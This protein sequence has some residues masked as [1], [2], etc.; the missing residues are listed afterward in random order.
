VTIPNATHQQAAAA[1][2]AMLLVHSADLSPDGDQV[3]WSGSHI[4]GDEEFIELRI[5]P[6]D[7][8]LAKLVGCSP[9]DHSPA[10]APDGV[11]VAF[12]STHDG[13]SSISLVD[14]VTME[15]R[16]L[17]DAGAT[18]F[19]ITG[20]P[21]WSPDSTRLAFTAVAT[22]RKAGDPYR[23]TRVVGWVDGLGL[24]DD[25]AADIF[26]VDA[27]TGEHTRLTADDW[28]N[29]SPCWTRDGEAVVYIASWSPD[30]WESVA[31]IRS[32]SLMGVVSD[33]GTGRA[34]LGVNTLEDGAVVASTPGPQPNGLGRL[35][36]VRP[37]TDIED[38][39]SALG[40]DI[41]GDIIGD[42]AIGFVDPD[43]RLLVSDGGAIVRVQVGDRL[44]VER[45]TLAGSFGSEV[46]LSGAGCFYPLAISGSYLLYGSGSLASPPDLYVRNLTT[47]RD[48]Q[49]SDTAAHNQTV[50]TKVVVEQFWANAN[51]GPPIDCKFLRPAHASTALPTVLLIHGG[52]KSAFG[53]AFF[54]DAR[55]L[56]EA[57]FGVLMANP[58]GSRGYGVDFLDAI[59]GDWGNLDFADLMAAVDKA[60]ALNLADPDR[61][62]VSGL[63]YGGY[64]SSWI[65]GHTHRF[66]GAVIENPVSNLWSMYG[67]SDV[68]M[69]F[70]PEVI[71]GTPATNFDEYVRM[72]PLTY[73]DQVRTPSLLILGEQDHRC[74]PEQ[75]KQFYSALR[76]AGCDAELLMLPGESH[77]GSAY[78]AVISR[79]VQNEALVEWMTR[80]VI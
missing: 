23:V 3:A 39:S 66:R 76:R 58:R 7:G 68:G 14:P 4:E 78:G 56:C 46:V 33:L 29:R 32:V 54:A 49:I 34:F 71:G 17:V 22:R 26:V 80:H 69:R 73:A 9:R 62:G 1:V 13:T 15:Y 65:V 77:G 75:G 72:S 31:V 40:L 59:T 50:L 45:V 6:T 11:A 28:A 60:I 55:V 63:S 57:G 2:N 10:W 43:P 41:N 27:L 48:T 35:L 53:E 25:M 24:V 12:L 61:L 42:V 64:M 44:E 8:K 36:L 52:P 18:E 16:V 70:L 30:T 5:G 47:G 21:V 74:P 37:G 79:R 38:R 67:T 20:P 51:G 19:K